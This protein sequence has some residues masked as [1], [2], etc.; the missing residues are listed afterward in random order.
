MPPL[1]PIFA[2]PLDERLRILEAIKITKTKTKC[3]RFTNHVM[4]ALLC[5]DMNDDDDENVKLYNRSFG[6]AKRYQLEYYAQIRRVFYSAYQDHEMMV[7]ILNKKVS[8]AI[9]RISSDSQKVID[10][11]INNL[12]SSMFSKIK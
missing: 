11:T 9:F 2:Y 4:P 10:D 12:F 1:K 8:K 5:L 7:D 6:N 3:W